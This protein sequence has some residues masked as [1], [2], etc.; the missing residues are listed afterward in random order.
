MNIINNYLK[1]IN[2]INKVS[3]NYKNFIFLIKK[4][5]LY[6]YKNCKR[7]KN[8]LRN[9]NI[10]IYK[11]NKN[12]DFPFI[13]V[14]SFKDQDL[15]SIN[16]N[17]I[18]K[19]LFSSGT[20]NQKLSKIHLDKINAK[21]QIIALKKIVCSILGNSRLPMLIFEK[22]PK[23]LEKRKFG[24]KIAAIYG[25][26]IFGKSH[27]YCIDKNNNLNYSLLNN[28]LKKFAN[29]SFLIFGFTSSI[30]LNL[31]KNF[32]KNKINQD[33]SKGIL[34][35]GGG[36]K[37][38]EY[39]KIDNLKFKKKL[40]KNVNLKRIINY[41]G[42]VEQTGSIFLECEKCNVFHTNPF[43]DVIVRD[44]FLNKSKENE[45]GILQLLSILPSSYP[46]NSILFEDEGMIIS[47]KN[48]NCNNT[49]K[50]FQ[51]LGRIPRAEVRG[52]SDA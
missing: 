17:K 36:W 4:Q 16:K 23:I 18:F 14:N 12:Y 27:T 35:H 25:F 32:K 50:S 48:K 1:K 7:Y 51:I 10:N 45:K 6:H 33:F 47:F 42:V 43:N 11:I 46:G 8:F 44:K 15:L 41:Y 38:L 34:I 31:I 49:G 2:N 21:N 19:T 22:D 29:Q 52:C 3:E 24:A 13:H 40:K 37:K 9:Q 39:E 30:Y 28:F 26:S 5:F 20:S